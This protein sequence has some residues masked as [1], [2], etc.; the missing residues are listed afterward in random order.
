MKT[1][2]EARRNAA[3]ASEIS[4]PPETAKRA[5]NAPARPLARLR[6]SWNWI[7]AN[8][9]R[10]SPVRRDADGMPI[11]EDVEALVDRLQ[12]AGRLGAEWI[13]PTFSPIR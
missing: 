2:L 4:A 5:Q 10:Y 6:H 1:T 13:P 7:P 12:L 9:R 11:T 3:G 8:R